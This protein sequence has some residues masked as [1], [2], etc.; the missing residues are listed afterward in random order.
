MPTADSPLQKSHTLAE[1]LSQPE[2]WL[3]ALQEA[4]SSPAF[5]SAVEQAS[6][7]R[8]WLFLGCGTSFYLAEAAAATWTLL[9]NESARA[10]PASEPLLFPDLARLRAPGLQAVVISRSGHTSE[11]IRVA[12]ILA[13]DYKVPAL[14]I[15]CTSGSPLAQ[16]CDLTI[17]IPAADEKS[18][19]MTRSFSSMLLALQHLAASCAADPR[20]IL[21]AAAAVSAQLTSEMQ[22]FNRRIEAFVADREFKDYVFLA[23]G[24][25]YAVAR[26]ASLKVTEMSC[27]YGQTYHTLEFRHGPKAI[28][29]PETCLTF[30]LSESG[31]EPECETL[32][33]MK[34][35]G[36][37][38][39]TVCNRASEAVRRSSDLVLELG[40]AAPEISLLAPFVV[41]AQLLGFHT[42]TKKGL[43][44]DHPRHLSRV[45][46]LD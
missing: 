1:I 41:P 12:Q 8:E 40:A 26:E 7:R 46:I 36:G 19:V 25:F 45:V 39:I 5:R 9:T 10:L 44:P 38:I 3:S 33:E 30:F 29:A 35:L 22:G 18:T 42:G 11:A 6:S 23:Q 34:E 43:D 32:F 17:E 14:G 31:Y 16:T 15:T 24:P 4:Q 13:R 20:T 2:V 28:V 37:T 27:S 21:E